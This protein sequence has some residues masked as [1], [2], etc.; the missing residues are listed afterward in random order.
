M[1]RPLPLLLTAALS[2]AAGSTLLVARQSVG[3][4]E[5]P[6]QPARIEAPSCAATMDDWMVSSTWPEEEILLGDQIYSRARLWNLVGSRGNAVA[7]LALAMATT[8]LNVA[9]GAEPTADVIEA[10]F[11]ADA[12]L[13]DEHEEAQR[14]QQNHSEIRTLVDTLVSFNDW[15]AAASSCARNGGALAM[16]RGG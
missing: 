4:E 5:E 14:S 1:A 12:W 8:Q 10:L 2:A 16:A 9:A 6:P 3:Q 15:A 13:L 7:D 11:R